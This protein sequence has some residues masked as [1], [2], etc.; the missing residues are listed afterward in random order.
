MLTSTQLTIDGQAIPSLF[1]GMNLHSEISSQIHQNV[2]TGYWWLNMILVTL[3]SGVAMRLFQDLWWIQYIKDWFSGSEKIYFQAYSCKIEYDEDGL[4]EMNS[5]NNK[6][7]QAAVLFYTSSRLPPIDKTSLFFKINWETEDKSDRDAICEGKYFHLPTTRF[8]IE[9]IGIK[10]DILED[11]KDDSGKDEWR[12]NTQKNKNK[13]VKHLSMILDGP[14]RESVEK[15]IQKCIEAYTKVFY[16]PDDNKP[17]LFTLLCDDKERILFEDC[18]LYAP[19]KSFNTLFFKEKNT[20][21]ETL[22]SFVHRKK[23]FLK[24]LERPWRL[25]IMLHGPPGTGKSSLIKAIAN[26][27]KRNVFIIPLNY[28]TTGTQLRNLFHREE[29]FTKSEDSNYPNSK[30]IKMN[31]RFYVFEE[32]DTQNDLLKRKEDENATALEVDEKKENIEI[33]KSM[34]TAMKKMSLDKNKNGDATTYMSPYLDRDKVNLGTFLNCLDG[35]T[36]PGGIMYCFTTNHVDKL[37]KAFMRDG[38]IHINLELGYSRPEDIRDILEFHYSTLTGKKVKIELEDI[39]TDVKISGAKIESICNICTTAE[40]AVKK[41]QDHDNGVLNWSSD[42]MSSEP[43]SPSLI[44]LT[45]ANREREEMLD[46]PVGKSDK[47]LKHRHV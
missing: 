12:S 47:I 2:D 35:I 42:D 27:T 44:T 19:E 18:G 6:H 29:I 23:G 14:D 33:M 26:Y 34:A 30:R 37:D 3:L 17:R 36:D 43:S 41:I 7:I 39:P 45:V 38:R 20:V 5:R 32:V 21:V 10:Y 16:A 40:Q 46:T 9:G 22:E 13:C 25:G 11:I 31:K 4:A 24:E 15:F 8:I 1:M 28:I